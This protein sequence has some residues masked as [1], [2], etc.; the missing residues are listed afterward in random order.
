ML[1]FLGADGMKNMK[2]APQGGDS[3]VYYGAS[4]QQSQIRNPAKDSSACFFS[5]TFHALRVRFNS[6]QAKGGRSVNRTMKACVLGCI[7][8]VLTIIAFADEIPIGFISYDVNIPRSVATLDISNQTGPNAS[9][10]PDMTFPVTT[11]VN[12]SGLS[13]TVDLSNGSVL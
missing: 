2:K 3:G 11:P 8:M 10:F 5:T 7:V 1:G 13:L 6:V 12:L 9:V 4:P